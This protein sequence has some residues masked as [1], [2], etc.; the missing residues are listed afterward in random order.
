MH[1]GLLSF[2]PYALCAF[3]SIGA[4]GVG[5]ATWLTDYRGNW[6][7]AAVL[8]HLLLGVGFAL[9]ALSSGPVPL[10]PRQMIAF[11]VRDVFFAAGS[12]G[13]VA[14][15]VYLF[16]QLRDW[17][18]WNRCRLSHWWLILRRWLLRWMA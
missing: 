6:I 16:G 8:A 14:L 7:P 3:V 12:A 4:A 2:E 17:W 15:A 10:V 11:F 9:L 13:V 1:E 18:E 5:L